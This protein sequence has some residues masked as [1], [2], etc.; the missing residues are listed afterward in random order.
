MPQTVA[1]FYRFVDLPDCETFRDRLETECRTHEVRGMIILATEGLNATIAGPKPDVE[2]I[3]QFIRADQRF[4]GMPHRECETDRDTFHRLRLVIRQE[5]VTLGDPSINPNDAVGEY[6]A[7]EDWNALISDPE[8]LLIDTRNDYEVELGTFQ[9]A[10]NPHTATFGEWNAYVQ[11]QL[12]E[13]KHKKVAM[14]CTG[15]IRC[16]NGHRNHPR[17]SPRGTPGSLDSS[18]SLRACS[19][20]AGLHR[21]RRLRTHSRCNEG[22]PVFPP[23][24]YTWTHPDRVWVRR[25]PRSSIDRVATSSCLLV[26]MLCDRRQR[27]AP[28]F[29]PSLLSLETDPEL[30]KLVLLLLA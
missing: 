10:T 29:F 27:H 22:C 8:V 24:A 25:R 2:A 23:I 20:R 11:S 28:L 16:S 17:A 21:P 5:I 4:A 9:G 13:A 3:L 19:E 15:G 26:A 1:T 18:R 7:P 14:F 6:V 12:A 30:F